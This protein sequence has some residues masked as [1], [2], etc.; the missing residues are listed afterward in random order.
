DELKDQYGP[1]VEAAAE[2]LTNIGQLS[3]GVVQ[4]AKGFH[5]LKLQGRQAALNLTVDQVKPQVQHILLNERRMQ[6][7]AALLDRL[8]KEQ[9]YSVKDDALAKV[10]VDMKAPTAEQKGPAQQLVPAPMLQGATQ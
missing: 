2:R 1:E 6:N 10:E 5:I 8:K 3:D 7:Y 9:S 4:T